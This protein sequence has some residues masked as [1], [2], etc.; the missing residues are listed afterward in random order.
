MVDQIHKERVIKKLQIKG[1]GELV[2]FREFYWKIT[3]IEPFSVLE[4]GNEPGFK[5]PRLN[6]RSS[7]GTDT[8]PL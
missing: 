2:H 7:T 3:A 5:T 1:D 8:F 6:H 4:V